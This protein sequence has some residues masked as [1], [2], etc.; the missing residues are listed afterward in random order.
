M[1]AS[2]E[3]YRGLLG[4]VGRYRRDQLVKALLQS[5][6]VA[7]VRHNGVRGSGFGRLRLRQWYGREPFEGL[8]AP[9]EMAA[10]PLNHQPMYAQKAMAITIAAI[11]MCPLL[12]ARTEPGGRGPW[13]RHRSQAC[14]ET[15]AE[16]PT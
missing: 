3:H 7:V 8:P 1:G 13:S 9:D 5:F 11:S 4:G 12:P 10:S 16:G 14:G 2:S 6:H 15:W